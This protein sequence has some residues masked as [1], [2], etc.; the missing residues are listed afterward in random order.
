[1]AIRPEDAFPGKIAA[2]SPSYPQGQARDVSSPS[3]GTGTPWNALNINEWY[4]WTQALLDEA[5]IAPNGLPETVGNSQYLTAITTL[6]NNAVVG[7]KQAIRPIG[8][9][10]ESTDP[11]DP[12]TVFGFGTWEAYGAGRVTV[13]RDAADTDFNTVGQT[14]GSKTHVLTVGQMPA[15]THNTARI[16]GG[17]GGGSEPNEALDPTNLGEVSSSTGSG[18]PHNN[19]QPYIVVYRWRRTA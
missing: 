17:D 5:G 14:G 8:S 9:L 7:L 10:Y 16:I 4:G 12:A 13:C 6:I 15:H 3:D 11:T 19:V 1:M 18:Q 2:S